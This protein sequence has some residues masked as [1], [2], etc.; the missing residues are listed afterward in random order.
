M[1]FSFS[2]KQRSAVMCAHSNEIT[3]EI[4]GLNRSV[5]EQ[6]GRV[7][8]SYVKDAYPSVWK[9]L[10]ELPSVEGDEPEA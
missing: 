9:E 7:S 3:T 6:C 2:A 10:D 1:G 8:V 5:C 4:A